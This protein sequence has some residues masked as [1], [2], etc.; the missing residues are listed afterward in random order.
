MSPITLTAKTIQQP[1]DESTTASP[2]NNSPAEQKV[3]EGEGGS[4]QKSEDGS[5]GSSNG[6]GSSRGGYSADCSSSDTSS[7]NFARGKSAT[8]GVQVAVGNLNL[9]ASKPEQG[10]SSQ[11]NAKDDGKGHAT[12]APNTDTESPVVESLSGKDKSRSANHVSTKIGALDEMLQQGRRLET[13]P[14]IVPGQAAVLPQWNGIRISHPMDP[15]IDLTAVGHLQSL[16]VP[17]QQ[18]DVQA[19]AKGSV[20]TASTP[21]PSVENYL[22]LMEVRIT[23][24]MVIE[25]V[26]NRSNLLATTGHSTLLR[27][28]WFPSA[29]P[30]SRSSGT[31]LVARGK[32]GK[33]IWHPILGGIYIFF[34]LN[35]EK[36]IRFKLRSKA[37]ISSRE[38]TACCCCARNN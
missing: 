24:N 19:I 10:D 13:E 18:S 34:H 11:T 26:W 29:G 25:L 38:T 3:E 15:R 30:Q 1:P 4:Q 36:L 22:H 5:E 32:W 2:D 27:F 6:R 33:C 28:V 12:Q 35:R 23:L 17:V 37:S 21:A 20:Y 7:E 31:R 9:D 8:E 14:L 16:P